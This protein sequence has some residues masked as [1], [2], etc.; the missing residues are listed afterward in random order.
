MD[1][2]V[3]LFSIVATSQDGATLQINGDMVAE[4]LDNEYEVVEVLAKI[5][6]DIENRVHPFTARVV[7]ADHIEEAIESR[8]EDTDE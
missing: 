3:V 8:K 4:I 7:E 1:Q 6:H 2:P 5:I